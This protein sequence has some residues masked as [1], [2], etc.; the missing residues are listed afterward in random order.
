MKKIYLQLCCLFLTVN[1]FSQ[2]LRFNDYSINYNIQ[3]AGMQAY[4]DSAHIFMPDSMFYHEG[5]EYSQFKQW[6]HFWGERLFPDGDFDL[7]FSR[8]KQG[9]DDIGQRSST[10]N[11][12]WHEIGPIDKPS[13]AMTGFNGG[14]SAGIGPIEF[15]RFYKNNTQNMLCGS[16][17]GG[18]FYSNNGGETWVNAGSDH[19]SGIAAVTWAE[20]KSDDP[21]VVF[22]SSGM[23]ADNEAGSIQ[24]L[25]GIF[26]S[27]KNGTITPNTTWDRIADYSSLGVTTNC[28]IKKILTDPV[29]PDILYVITSEG[30]FRS[31]NVNSANPTWSSL[32]TDNVFDLEMNPNFHLT[33]YASFNSPSINSHLIKYSTD[34]GANWN[35]LTNLP[36]YTASQIAHVTIEVSDPFPNNIYLFYYLTVPQGAPHK[37][38]LYRYNYFSLTYSQI[39]SISDT[40]FSNFGNGTAFGISKSGSDEII[41]IANNDRYR[42]YV[43]G[44]KTVFTS[45]SS[46][47][48]EYHVDMEGFTFNP[49]DANEIWMACHGATYKSS[50][51]GDNWQPK[52]KGV[53]VAMVYNLATSYENAE[54]ILVSTYHDGDILT[55]DA[56]SNNGDASWKYIWGGDGQSVL[57]DRK[58]PDNMYASGVSSSWATTNDGGVTPFTPVAFYTTQ[59]WFTSYAILNK[60]EPKIIYG[61]KNREINRSFDAQSTSSSGSIISNIAAVAG[62]S[63]ACA[64]VSS[65]Y[66]FENNK[67]LLIA[68]FYNCTDIDLYYTLKATDPNINP[69]TDWHKINLGNDGRGVYDVEIDPLNSNN[70]YVALYPDWSGGSMKIINKVENFTSANP[71]I[72]N[73]TSNFPTTGIQHDCMVLEKGSDGGIYVATD[74]GAVFYTNNKLFAS[75]PTDAWVQFG[76]NY[77]HCITNGLEINYKINKIRAV[78]YGRGVWEADLYC[79]QTGPLALS[80]NE[81]QNKFEEADGLITSVQTF[82]QDL[83]ITYRATD[84][85]KLLPGFLATATTNSNFTAYIHP[86]STP[87]N[88]FRKLNVN[89]NDN[90]TQ[91]YI[92]SEKAQPHNNIGIIP[93]P[94]NGTFQISITK[95]NQAIGVKD[96]KVYD[97]IG[98]VIWENNTPSGNLFN[99]DISGYAPGIYY[100]RVINEAGD[101]DLRKLIKQ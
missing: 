26:R 78:P 6:E 13:G 67:D 19:W 85:V 31:S 77:P 71:N 100:V 44:V 59:Q 10:Y 97:M 39:N 33:L 38:V 62:V 73:L 63:S 60:E 11:A 53:G 16:T 20:F 3:K 64:D 2:N 49:N 83:N 9:Y 15:V 56:Y 48:Y 32:L 93:N 45:G 61:R 58:N 70:I 79:P 4:L 22:A 35:V 65:F 25:G 72:I 14:Q 42:R 23:P 92:S 66:S 51:Q 75:S 12:V 86:C 99:V 41:M 95:N 80:G 18:L 21:E 37:G 8:L 27:Q 88:S 46:N 36:V 30:L 5:G 17:N 1:L 74:I 101:M 52:M 94:N 54:D 57:I 69:I 68:G 40:V 28:I 55:K 91:E 47:K 76:T 81:V 89:N 87:G 50:N 82:N 90:P 96:V 84:E 43:N 29:N 24:S 7:Y 34:G 98:K